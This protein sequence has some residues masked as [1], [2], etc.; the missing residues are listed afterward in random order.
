MIRDV[1]NRF[2][3][4]RGK[5]PDYSTG[6]WVEITDYKTDEN[7]RYFIR[8]LEQQHEVYV[9]WRQSRHSQESARAAYGENQ[10]EDSDVKCA[11]FTPNR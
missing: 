11:E 10:A 4:V 2:W 8:S 6:Q 3:H 9:E 7:D 5:S 1:S